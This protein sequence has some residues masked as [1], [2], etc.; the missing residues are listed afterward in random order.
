MHQF[1][2][3]RSA[4]LKTRT[5]L[6]HGK[7]RVAAA[8]VKSIDLETTNIKGIYTLGEDTTH[9]EKT[10]QPIHRLSAVRSNWAYG[11]PTYTLS[12]SASRSS[13]PS[14]SHRPALNG[15]GL[16]TRRCRRRTNRAATTRTLPWEQMQL[17]RS[18]TRLDPKRAAAAVQSRTVRLEV[19]HLQIASRWS[20]KLIPY[21]EVP[22]DRRR[23]GPPELHDLVLR[24][25]A[26]MVAGA[27]RARPRGRMRWANL[28]PHPNASRR[29]AQR[30]MRARHDYDVSYNTTSRSWREAN[31]QGLN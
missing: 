24:E 2:I 31:K 8:A 30:G 4:W 28:P 27:R 9:W 23:Q 21:G 25:A 29:P 14:T 12:S 6:S 10:Q 22:I 7:G 3:A 18:M 11:G 26:T 20:H 1:M 15:G 17:R 16:I 13:C 5:A 19:E